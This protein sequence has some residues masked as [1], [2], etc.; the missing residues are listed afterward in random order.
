MNKDFN[1]PILIEKEEIPN[2]TF[3][4]ETGPEK[5]T[6]ELKL[7]R[8]KIKESAILGNIHHSKVRI[9]FEDSEGLKEVRTTIW[10]ADDDFLLLKRGIFIPLNR[11]VRI[12]F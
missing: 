3:T 11:V 12:I 7:F 2:L 8:Q 9:V 6:T 10:S 4:K 5:T 1:S